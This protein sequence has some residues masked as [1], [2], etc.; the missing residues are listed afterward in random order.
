MS[1]YM[2]FHIDGICITE[3]KFLEVEFLDRRICSVLIL[4]DI[5]QMLSIDSLSLYTS[6]S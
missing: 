6:I 5:T 2:S 3:D 4:I 1:E